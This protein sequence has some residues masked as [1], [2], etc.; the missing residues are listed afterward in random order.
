MERYK[1]NNKNGVFFLFLS[2]FLLGMCFTGISEAGVK[3]SGWKEMNPSL[4]PDGTMENAGTYQYVS[5]GRYP[6]AS[7]GVGGYLT[8]P[9]MWRVLSADQTDPNRKAFLLSDKN[10]DAMPF[11]K[12]SSNNYGP[13]PIRKFLVSDDTTG[14]YTPSSFTGAEKSLV[15]VQAFTTYDGDNNPTGGTL[16]VDNAMFLLSSPDLMNPGYGFLSS[17]GADVNR[18]ARSTAYTASKPGGGSTGAAR[19]YWMRSSFVPGTNKALDVIG[20]GALGSDPVFLEAAVCPACILNLESVIFK[21]VSVFGTSAVAGS[22]DNPYVLYTQWT[23]A[24]ALSIENSGK[25]KLTFQNAISSVDHWPD[26][27][28]FILTTPS[29]NVIETVEPVRKRDRDSRSC[30][31][32]FTHYFIAGCGREFQRARHPEVYVQPGR[33]RN[34]G[35]RGDSQQRFS[36]GELRIWQWSVGDKQTRRTAVQR[37]DT[38]ER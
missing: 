10:L 15:A 2:L 35:R 32:R 22:K 4:T 33:E 16:T 21:S 3:L 13:S 9:I 28:D 5:F 36:F 23:P 17:D 7:D 11:N 19:Q 30:R 25:L 34:V 1:G 8:Q 38:D 29:G 20:G 27:T 18:V 6:Q 12:F 14:F 37:N 24:P 26:P 31:G